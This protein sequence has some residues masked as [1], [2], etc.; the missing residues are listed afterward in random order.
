M[1]L[2]GEQNGVDLGA[3]RRPHATRG[4][5][6]GPA[7]RRTQMTTKKKASKSKARRRTTT[8][9]KAA[10]AKATGDV[11]EKTFKGKTVR[12]TRDADGFHYDGKVWRP[13]TAIALAATGYKA[14]SGPAFFGLAKKA[15]K[16]GE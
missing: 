16:G 6:T 3:E 9:R 11:I 15:E 8:K 5:G 12:V 4:W 14:I 7:Q 10:P 1:A 2:S 13:L